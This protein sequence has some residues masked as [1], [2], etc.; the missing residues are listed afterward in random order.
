MMLMIF[1]VEIASF[2]ISYLPE[3]QNNQLYDLLKL[4]FYY[5]LQR[6]GVRRENVIKN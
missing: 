3:N 4:E 1:L 6:A 2:Q 5:V